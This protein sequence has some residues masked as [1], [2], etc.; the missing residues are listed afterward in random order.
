MSL[1]DFEAT[2]IPNAVSYAFCGPS[3]AFLCE[4]AQLMKQ[5]TD[6]EEL[7]SPEFR[8]FIERRRYDVATSSGFIINT[9]REL[10]SEFLDILALREDFLDKPIFAI[11]PLNPVPMH[12]NTDISHDECLEWLDGHPPCSV[13][14]VSFGTMSTISDEQVEQL[15][16]GLH[17][18]GHRFLWVLRDADLADI[19]SFESSSRR[20]PARFE[21]AV[22]GVGKVVRGWVPQLDVLAHRAIGGFMS[23]CGWN[24]CM[25]AVSYGVPV[26]AWPMHSDQPANARLLAEG[27]KVGVV[28]RGWDRRQEVVAAERVEE[29][30]RMVME[31]EEGR[32]MREKAR[33]MGEA[34]RAARKDGGSSKEALDMLVAH[35]RR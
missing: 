6:L 16:S 35:W 20:L 22:E 25:E 1:D 7:A 26:M 33:E 8:R 14:Y 10:E 24:S 29:V 18:S 4:L 17:R 2:A 5:G 28:V 12:S 34:V 30:V 11:G 3:A 15:A 13:V 23:H 19:F 21:K 32:R 27:L 9:C 31:G